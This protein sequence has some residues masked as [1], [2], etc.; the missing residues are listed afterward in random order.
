MKEDLINLII[1]KKLSKEY[2]EDSK[3]LI[4]L[5]IIEERYY[6]VLGCYK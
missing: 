3:K 4:N 6:F 5:R 2:L 1:K